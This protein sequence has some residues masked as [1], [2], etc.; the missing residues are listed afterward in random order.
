M[1][2][3]ARYRSKLNTFICIEKYFRSIVQYY[4]VFNNLYNSIFHYTRHPWPC[5][6]D[7]RNCSGRKTGSTT[8]LL[9]EDYAVQ[10]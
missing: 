6:H 5:S 10:K 8:D 3:F 7:N 1:D 2:Q 4:T 9:Q